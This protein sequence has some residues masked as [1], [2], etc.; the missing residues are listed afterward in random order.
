MNLDRPINQSEDLV[1][2]ALALAL[3]AIRAV[4]LPRSFAAR[5]LITIIFNREEQ[6]PNPV[7]LP[8]PVYSQYYNPPAFVT[9]P[10]CAS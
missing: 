5:V 1:A 2:T 3:A 10:L 8:I 7:N 4:T 6:Y 9:P